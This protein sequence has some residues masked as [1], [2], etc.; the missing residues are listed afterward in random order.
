MST[1][2]S[3]TIAIPAYNEAKYIESVIDGF[4]RQQYPNLCQIL[5]ADG[6]S[7]DGTQDIVSEISLRD[8]RV[9]LIENPHKIQSYALNIMLEEATSDIFLR[10]DAHCNYAS[11][12]IQRSVAALMGSGALNVGGAQRFVAETAFQAGVALS[13]RSILG[14]GGAKYRD[15]N[16]NG[17]SETVFLGCFWKECLL[18]IGGFNTATHPNE[19]AELNLRLLAKNANAVYISSDIKAWYYPRKNVKTLWQQFFKYGYSRCLTARRHPGKSPLRT[20]LPII[21]ILAIFLTSALATL[22]LG[23]HFTFLLV[24]STIAIPALESIRVT[25][26]YNSAFE[27]VF[28]RGSTSSYPSFL[29][30]CFYCWL[31]LLIMPLAYAS[32]GFF[33]ILR[34]QILRKDGW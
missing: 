6:G 17:N 23:Y 28:W 34:H 2:P 14:N 11:D 15:P 9:R 26:K 27:R 3:V 16:Y 20:K 32:G 29:S 21:G 1:F 30:R 19:D 18:E 24:L 10:A 33:Q 4:I 12:Y 7:Q 5:V 22:F 25:L 31:A 8:S 13:S